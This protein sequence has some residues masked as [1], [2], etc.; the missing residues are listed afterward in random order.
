VVFQNR[1]AHARNRFARD[2][3]RVTPSGLLGRM[4]GFRDRLDAAA[5][6]ADRSIDIR[7]EQHR[8][9]LDHAGRLVESLS[10]KAILERGF[11]LVRDGGDKPLKRAAEVKAGGALSIEFVDGRVQALAAG[12]GATS[13]PAPRKTPTKGAPPPKQGSLF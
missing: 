12:S 3:A 13:P 11:A 7:L 8:T 5:H 6:S 10:Y 2:A 9:R 1:V 4:A